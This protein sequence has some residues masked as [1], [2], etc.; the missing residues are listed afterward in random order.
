[1][2]ALALLAPAGAAAQERTVAAT[3]E[4][5]LRV[6]NDSA[7]VGFSVSRER[8]SRGAAL[9]AASAGLRRVIAAMQNASPASG[10]GDV[11]TGRISVRKPARGKRTVYRAAE[12]I[13]VTLHQPERAGDLVSAAIAAG[14]SGVSGP[15]FFVGD[16]EAA[17][18]RGLAAAFDAEGAGWHPRHPGGRHAGRG[19]QRSTKATA[20]NSFSAGFAEG[21]PKSALRQT[22]RRP[23]RPD[24]ATRP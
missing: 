14:A 17:F 9:Q 2:L 10:A 3:G 19:D 6:A 11:A 7:G 22:T 5:T 23:P 24:Q 16:T 13:G 12:G 21:A 4:A 18:R 1:M 8:R 15:S 20:P